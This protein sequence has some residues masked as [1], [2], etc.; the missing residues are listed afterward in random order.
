MV[1]MIAIPTSWIQVTVCW[2]FMGL[3]WVTVVLLAFSTS[4]RQVSP[5]G[6]RPFCSL[7]WVMAFLLLIPTSKKQV[8]NKFA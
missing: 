2:V 8:S 6:S 1:F 3:T 4:W 7:A 5:H